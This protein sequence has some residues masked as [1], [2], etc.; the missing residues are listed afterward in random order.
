[1]IA[2]VDYKAGNLTSVKLAFDALGAD[3]KVSS[4]RDVIRNAERIV[5][6]GVGAA[7]AAMDSIGHESQGRQGRRK[8]CRQESRTAQQRCALCRPGHRGIGMLG[9]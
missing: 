7:C 2:I 4:D 6:P 3:A 5:F 8:A 1:M 9:N